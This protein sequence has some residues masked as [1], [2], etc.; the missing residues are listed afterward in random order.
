MRKL[1]TFALIAVV[2]ISI[3]LVVLNRAGFGQEQGV[4][5]AVQDPTYDFAK[6]KQKGFY[7][8][9]VTEMNLDEGF[10]KDLGAVLNISIDNSFCSQGP[11][12]VC[13]RY[14]N[15]NRFEHVLKFDRLG[16]IEYYINWLSPEIP[17]VPGREPPATAQIDENKAVDVATRILREVALMLSRRGFNV[18]EWS[19]RPIYKNVSMEFIFAD[20]EKGVVYKVPGRVQVVFNASYAGVPVVGRYYVE[21]SLYSLK[22]V[23]LELDIF[24]FR[25]IKRIDAKNVLP[26]DA[27][28]KKHINMSLVRIVAKKDVKILNVTHIDVVYNI[29]NV[30]DK[31]YAI[32]FYKIRF[33][34]INATFYVPI[35][36]DEMLQEISKK[37]AEQQQQ[38]IEK[39]VIDPENVNRIVI[40]GRNNNTGEIG[41]VTIVEPQLI[42]KAINS[43]AN[44]IASKIAEGNFNITLSEDEVSTLLN[45]SDNYILI[46]LKN[47][48]VAKAGVDPIEKILTVDIT[49]IVSESDM[50]TVSKVDMYTCLKTVHGSWVCALRS[51]LISPIRH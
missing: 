32:P 16:R 49:T 21:L 29:V 5:I 26:V 23:D 18:S 7:I 27:A 14:D 33:L 43:V 19:F 38:K 6:I 37:M 50:G 45:R 11:L 41:V 51:L 25:P 4:V 3:V 22:P 39:I 15:S 24:N 40:K 2:A 44:V 17:L 48:I 30:S 36:E 8:L 42:E 1:L 46:E 20:I 28:I 47:P 34:G 13:R 35:A 12:I 10:V 9:Q 31:I